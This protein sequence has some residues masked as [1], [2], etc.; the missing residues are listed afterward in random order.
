MILS[1]ELDYVRLTDILKCIFQV[2]NLKQSSYP[3]NHQLILDWRILVLN[4]LSKCMLWLKLKFKPFSINLIWH[5]NATDRKNGKL[6]QLSLGH[7]LLFLSFDI[8]FKQLQLNIKHGHLL[9]NLRYKRKLYHV[10]KFI[11]L[12]WNETKIL[13][14][15]N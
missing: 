1:P 12:V 5:E 8:L 2:L 14:V 11:I 10:N 13:Q 7:P 4:K 3:H 6:N 9:L 15:S